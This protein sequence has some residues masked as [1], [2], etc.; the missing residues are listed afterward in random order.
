MLI[1]RRNLLKTTPIFLSPF[2]EAAQ[3]KMK[4]HL[5]CGSIGIKADQR[6]AIEYAAKYKFQA[7][8]PQPAYLA[9]LSNGE[10]DALN[11][12]LRQ[13]GLVWGCANMSVDFRKD[14]ATFRKEF[15]DLPKHA[16]ALKRAGVTRAGTYIGP[17]RDTLTFQENLLQ[18]AERLSECALAL[19]DQGVRLG[20]EYVGPKLNWSSRKFP[21]VHTMMEMKELIA[22]IH[23]PN[24]GFVLD[25]WH[26][27][28]A[29]ESVADLKTLT[30]KEIISVDL[31]DAPVNIPIDMQVDSRRE[32]PCA[33]G[34][35]DLAGFLNTLNALNYD[36][37]VR[38]EPF[39]STLRAMSP[40]LVLPAVA[41]SMYKAFALI[42]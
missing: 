32:L 36:G 4:I 25:S 10:I 15:N 23:K 7:V 27:Y 11:G 41:D 37:P 1:T 21:F 6:Q 42:R 19:G 33:T 38:C 40:E 12:E 28:T 16:V 2:A 17:A 31:N 18:H 22:A 3:T 35:I 39:N 30:N 14:G 13:K 5:T 24:V 9:T 26:W 29:G 20:L 8:E 34:V